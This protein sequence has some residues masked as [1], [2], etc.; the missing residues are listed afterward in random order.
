MT[1]PTI[2]LTEYLRKLG[3]AQDQDFL[4]ESV[5]LMSQMLME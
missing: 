1:D 2:A 3:V 5:R 4:R